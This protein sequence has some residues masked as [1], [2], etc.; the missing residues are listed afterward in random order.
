MTFP[1]TPLVDIKRR[2]SNKLLK[3]E[4]AYPLLPIP[5]GKTVL[6]RYES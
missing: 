6:L 4:M 5:E 3:S 2:T 1:L